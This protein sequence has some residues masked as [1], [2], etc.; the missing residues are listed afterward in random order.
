MG[1]THHWDRPATIPVAIFHQICTDLKRLLP[2]LEQAGV[3]LG[4][5][6]GLELPEIGPE[7]IGFNGAIHCG[8]QVNPEIRLPWPTPTATGIGNN[9]GLEATLPYRTCNGDCSYESV[10]FERC[11]NPEQADSDGVFSGFC[12]TGFRPYDLAVTAFLIVAKYH[13]PSAM[14]I[15]TDGHQ[16]QWNDA[17]LLC[18]N[19]LGYGLEFIIDSKQFLVTSR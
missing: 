15:G 10:W 17:R 7:F 11:M 12:K 19:V 6:Y 5:A 8:H 4:N 16:P 9:Q 14:L 18:Q 13:L 1:Y 3:S 2:A